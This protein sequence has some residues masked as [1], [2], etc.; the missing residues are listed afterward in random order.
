[1]WRAPTS[2]HISALLPGIHGSA[3]ALTNT[4]LTASINQNFNV[5]TF[6]LD[7]TWELDLWGRVRRQV[8]AAHARLTAATNEIESVKLSIQAEVAI[9]YFSMRA[10][11]SQL[12]RFCSKPSRPSPGLSN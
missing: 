4:P 5:F 9:D 12:R 11:E 3:T 2:F 8:E 10:L 1:M 7:S 6:A